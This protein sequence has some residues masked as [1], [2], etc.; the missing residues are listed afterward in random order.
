[1]NINEFI[2]KFKNHP[3]LFLGTGIGLRYL[4]QS[5]NWEDLLK[6]IAIDY[7][8]EEYFLDLKQR[9]LKDNKCDYSKVAKEMEIS[10][11][12]YCQNN[13]DGQYKDINDLFFENARNNIN[14]SRLKLYIAKMLSPCEL[15]LDKAEELKLFQKSKKNIASIITTN[16]DCFVEKFL[17]FQPLIGNDI[18]LSNP[19]GSV[20]K[21]HGCVTRPDKIII[22]SDDYS[23]FAK[24][25][26]LI[27]AQ[28]LSLFIHHP[29]IFMGYG[30]NDS[31]IKDILKT[32][33]SYVECNSEQSKQIRDNFL[34][35]EYEKD[36][37]NDIVVE[38]DID[39][40]NYGVI[41]INK[42]KTDNYSRIFESLEKLTLPVSVM[43]IRKVQTVVK[44]IYA[45][46]EI[47][48]SVAEDLDDL[49]NGEKI[50]AIGSKDKVY[51]YKN[52]NDMIAEY[53]QLIENRAINI[54]ELINKQSISSTQFFP[55]FGFSKVCK[56]IQRSSE[57]KLQ[58]KKKLRE[59]QKKNTNLSGKYKSI[60]DMKKNKVAES[61]FYNELTLSILNGT[62]DLKEVK[63]YL[64]NF[65]EKMRTDYKKV[66][67]AYDLKMYGS[68]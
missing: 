35:V 54:I 23:E 38:H 55:I 62:M 22:T 33:F 14:V 4:K 9:F 6:C 46:G 8:S 12:E 59:L 19:Y 64:V 27:R 58:Q 20:Y 53:F 66:L 29:I 48:V 50:L 32:I 11:T 31:D 25:Y 26:E 65:P 63:E 68:N 43:D 41:Q 47:K 67:C 13:R 52:Y 34:L 21:I 42:L 17:N 36:S 57:L 16:Y 37:D 2:V 30:V 45:G 7:K 56:T 18:L 60:S 44:Q 15:H 40:E 49:E 24:R 3:I 1:M 39:M 28:L 51:I 5:Y 61:Y 10:F